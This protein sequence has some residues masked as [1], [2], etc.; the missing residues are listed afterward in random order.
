M[1]QP[2]LVLP[3]CSNPHLKCNSQHGRILIPTQLTI[4]ARSNSCFSLV[5]SFILLMSGLWLPPSFGSGHL[6]IEI[7]HEWLLWKQIKQ[8]KNKGRYHPHH[9]SSFSWKVH[10]L[11]FRS[12][13]TIFVWKRKQGYWIKCATIVGTFDTMS[14]IYLLSLS[15]NCSSGIKLGWWPDN[16]SGN[17]VSTEKYKRAKTCHVSQVLNLKYPKDT[18]E[19]ITH[20][21]RL[22]KWFWLPKGSDERRGQ[23]RVS[24]CSFFSSN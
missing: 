15:E 19:H 8:K 10:V 3:V 23:V 17:H 2:R 11:V 5:S 13:S 12:V 18:Q 21:L 16:G 20:Y 14:I 9:S 6:P 1:I 7:L 22:A 4:P 24:L